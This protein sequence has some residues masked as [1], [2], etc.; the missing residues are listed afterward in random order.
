MT[1]RELHDLQA[2]N[3]KILDSPYVSAHNM[4]E[5]HLSF[6]IIRGAST[7]T[8]VQRI[9]AEQS[10]I[11]RRLLDLEGIDSIQTGLRNTK[12]SGEDDMNVDLPLE[13]PAS[14]TLL[15]KQKALLQYVG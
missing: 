12:L 2:R 4:L 8:Y 5:L 7:S 15:A 9:S 6:A 10:A 14:R 11:D 3:I 1:V 13:P